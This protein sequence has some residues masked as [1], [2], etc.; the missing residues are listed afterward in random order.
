MNCVK[1]GVTRKL[2]LPKYGYVSL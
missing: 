1:V 2:G